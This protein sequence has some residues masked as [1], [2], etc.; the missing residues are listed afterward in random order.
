[1]AI[2]SIG[3]LWVYSN[4]GRFKNTSGAELEEV[5]GTNYSPTIKDSAI[6]DTKTKVDTSLKKGPAK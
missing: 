6:R 1:M 5:A 3:L 4:S 2:M